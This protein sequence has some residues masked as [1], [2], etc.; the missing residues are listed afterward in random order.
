MKQLTGQ[1]LEALKKVNSKDYS[2]ME[3]AIEMQ[4]ERTNVSSILTYLKGLGYLSVEQ[5]K[6]DARKRLY[7]ITDQGKTELGV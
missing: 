1:K 2:V 7:S 5:S 3:L 4:T 6:E